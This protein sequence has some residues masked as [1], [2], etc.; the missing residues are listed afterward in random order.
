MYSLYKEVRLPETGE[1]VGTGWLPPLPDLRDYTE[2]HPQIAAMA[3]QLGLEVPTKGP[4][5]L[6]PVDLRQWCSPIENQLNLGSCSAHAAVGILEYF[7]QRAYHEFIN[8]SRLFVYKTTRNLLQVTG[9]TGAWLRNAMGALVLLGVPPE[10]YWQYNVPDFDKEPPAFVYSLAGNY[11]SVK[12]FCHDPLG[13][14][15]PK[16]AVL[17]S[18]KRYLAAGIPSMF[19][20][21]GFP[22]FSNSN[23]KGGIPLPCPGE[24]AQWGHAIDA[25][26]YDDTK[27]ITNTQCKLT[28]TGAFLIRNSW[29]PGWGDQGYGW[30]PYQ[31]VLAGLALDFWSLLSMEWVA[32]KQFGI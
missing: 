13:Q 12:Y 25:V 26:G 23:V 15:I 5:A 21:Y 4:Q 16:P 7:Q 24:Q 22:S 28:T 6:P 2:K 11:E 3:K 14:N 30:L 32:T 31:Y 19:G 17:E 27:Q 29:G 1:V 20:F 9:D 8:G 18:V 10:T